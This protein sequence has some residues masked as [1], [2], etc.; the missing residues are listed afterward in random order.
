MNNKSSFVLLLAAFT[1]I[2]LIYTVLT[3]KQAGHDLFSVF[4]ASI[5]SLDWNGQ[6]NVDFSMYFTLSGL[7]IVWRNNFK[8]W[9]FPL[10]LCA[11]VI[12]M[13]VF[14]PYLIFLCLSEKGDMRQ[15]LL[16]PQRM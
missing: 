11:A 3:F 5:L 1:A 10:A 6:F 12:G 14:A 15:V 8:V 9:S 4:V 16:G 2:I 7:W 13:I